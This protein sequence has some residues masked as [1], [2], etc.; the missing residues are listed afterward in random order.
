MQVAAYVADACDVIRVPALAAVG[1]VRVG[2][3]EGVGAG[4]AFD[5]GG[6][7]EG[8]EVAGVGG[9]GW[10]WRGGVRVAVGI[11][12]TVVVEGLWAVRGRWFMGLEESVCQ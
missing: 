4:G 3:D 5:E 7:G 12:W 8:P 1:V 2:L 10:G 11:V 6:G 9:C